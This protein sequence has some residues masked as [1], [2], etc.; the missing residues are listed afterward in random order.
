MSERP[1]EA[2]EV[3]TRL[4]KCALEIEDSRSYWAHADGVGGVRAKLAFD[5]YWFGARSL[6]R[7]EVLLANMRA[8]FEAFPA[9][10]EGLHRW[11]HMSPDT[12]RVICHWH[13]QLADPLYRAFTG[14]YLVNRRAGPRVEVTRDM[15][16]AWVGQ[17]G[18][19]RWTMATR[20]QFAS[21]LLSGAFSAGLIATNRD[22]RPVVIPRVPDDALEYLLYLLREVQF[23]G[24][25]IENPYAA[26][27]G[28]EGSSLEDRLR[29]LQGLV[30]RRQGDLLDFG[31]QY[32]DIR[33]WADANIDSATERA[34]GAAG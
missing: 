13:L 1:R 26:S 27:V 28:L 17:Q 2:T 29:R 8:R 4:L 6:S 20:I 32:S 33:A 16:V 30:F 10:L 25:L 19:D 15:V 9:A 21:K 34:A 14:H 7:I 22:P 18:P 23:A 31:W 24:T 3:H 12:R 11:P 5:K